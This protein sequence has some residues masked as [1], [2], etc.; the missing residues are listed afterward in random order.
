MSVCGL[1]LRRV[2]QWTDGIDEGAG[3]PEDGIA[4][5]VRYLLIVD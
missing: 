4:P 1:L 3:I 5:L 2:G